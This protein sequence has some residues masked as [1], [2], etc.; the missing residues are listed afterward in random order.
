MTFYECSL[1][2]SLATLP[3]LQAI[4]QQVNKETDTT[5]QARYTKGK[6]H[7]NQSATTQ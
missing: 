4:N 7:T 3:F 2:S 6:F 1:A 5:Q